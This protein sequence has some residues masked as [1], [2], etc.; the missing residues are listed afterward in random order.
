MK[1]QLLQVFI[2]DDEQEVRDSLFK[3][4]SLHGFKVNTYADAQ[5]YLD[6]LNQTEVGCLVSDIDMEGLSGLEL[7]VA[8]NELKCIRPTIFITGHADVNI[9]VKAMKLGAVDFIEKPFDPEILLAKVTTAIDLFSERISVLNRYRLLTKKE[10]EV[11]HFVVRGDNNRVIGEKLFIS[12]PTVEA[13]RSKVM[14][15]MQVNSVAE[16]VR[17]SMLMS[18]LDG[19]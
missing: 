15:K 14:K 11:F 8:L 2:V 3:F 18:P 6:D 13:H 5:S 17:A 10:I 16:L 7:Q 12:M 19:N 9:A 1:D 4:F